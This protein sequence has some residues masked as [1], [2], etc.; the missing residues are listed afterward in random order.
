MPSWITSAESNGAHLAPLKAQFTR[1]NAKNLYHATSLVLGA[2]A[3][4]K[5][6]LADLAAVKV[7]AAPKEVLL[8]RS[9][10]SYR[11]LETLNSVSR[12]F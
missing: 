8:T 4:N 10:A 7:R 12:T 5:D 2:A 11:P 3:G 9:Q 1:L 6:Q